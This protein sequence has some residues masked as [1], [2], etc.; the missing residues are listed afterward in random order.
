[1]SPYTSVIVILMM[2]LA[3]TLTASAQREQINCGR[4]KPSA[5]YHT[6][7]KTVVN[8]LVNE[9]P[10]SQIR[11]SQSPDNSVGSAAGSAICYARVATDCRGCLK[12]AR[13]VLLGC[14]STVG[15][16]SGDVCAMV[17]WRIFD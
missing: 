6:A 3:V 8:T 1:M 14:D 11:L 17:F 12:K 15:V 13:D 4:E 5:S 16:Y 2:A 10:G 9:T 7:V